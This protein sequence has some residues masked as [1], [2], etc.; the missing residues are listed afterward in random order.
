MVNIELKRVVVT[1]LGAITPVG[2]TVSEYWQ[3]LILG[4]SGI[5]RITLFDAANHGCQIAGE[6][7]GFNP[8]DYLERKDIKRTDRFVQFAIAASQ[9]ALADANFAI[10]EL[11]AEQI[12]VIILLVLGLVEFRF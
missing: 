4:C 5:S 1:G 2:N 12:G 7:K 8:L 6:V 10:T 3:N 11:N 9:Q